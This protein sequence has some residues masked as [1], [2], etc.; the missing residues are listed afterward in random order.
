MGFLWEQE[1]DL[2]RHSGWWLVLVQG[3]SQK[4]LLHRARCRSGEKNSSERMT[5]L[6][7]VSAGSGTAAFFFSGAIAGAAT[8]FG[9]ARLGSG[10]GS[11]RQASGCEDNGEDTSHGMV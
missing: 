8:R 7:L 5:L 10:A 3:A 6:L 1:V 2:I 9:V 4:K 11:E